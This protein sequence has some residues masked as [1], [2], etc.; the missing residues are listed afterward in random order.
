VIPAEG[1]KP[2]RLTSDAANE[3]RPS[4]SHDGQW[5]YFGWDK[6]GESRIWKIHPSGGEPVQVS[7]HGG[8]AFETADGQWL[9]VVNGSTTLRM[10]PDG[11]EET[12]VRDGIAADH[13]ILGGR[14][15][16]FVTPAGDL[17]RAAFG[18]SALET[19]YHFDGAGVPVGGGTAIAVPTRAG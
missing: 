2:A 13:W 15:V 11:S 16:F 3:V 9:C 14:H 6:G 12:S 10:R 19:I 4:W 5:I 17:Q 7:R 8:H 18:P 1:R